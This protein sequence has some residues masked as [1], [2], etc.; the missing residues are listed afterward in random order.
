MASSLHGEGIINSLIDNL[1]FEAHLPFYRYC[2]PGTRL[3]ENLAAGVKPL[4][5]LDSHCRDHDI[6][7]SQSSDI[8]KR[9]EADRIL[10]QQAIERLQ[11]KDSGLYEK[12]SSS[13]VKNIMREK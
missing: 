6:A 13:L 12:I 8:S 2:G 9:H 4:N 5:K 11:S 10:I 1:K 3:K 7:Y